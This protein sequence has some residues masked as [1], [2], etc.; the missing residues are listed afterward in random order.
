MSYTDN[1]KQL[2]AS[3]IKTNDNQEITGQIMFEVLNAML[4][5]TE[6]AY[7]LIE[8][9]EV[10]GIALLQELGDSEVM[11]ISQKIITQNIQQLQNLISEA[12]K[13]NAVLVNGKNVVHDKI[14]YIDLPEAITVEGETL[15]I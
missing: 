12:G 13:V 14:A 3:T 15:I 7:K 5:A 4:D 9:I 11:G 1:I 8:S 2:I 10:G 6:Q